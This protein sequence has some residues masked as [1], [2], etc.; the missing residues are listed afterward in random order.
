MKS[1]RG[2]V[3]VFESRISIDRLRLLIAKLEHQTRFGNG[4]NALMFIFGCLA[5]QFSSLVL[6]DRYR[7]ALRDLSL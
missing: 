7:Y 5:S 2:E 4:A 1:Q 3:V 6:K